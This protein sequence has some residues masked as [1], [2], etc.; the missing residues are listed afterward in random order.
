[1]R[2]VLVVILYSRLSKDSNI[3]L[4]CMGGINVFCIDGSNVGCV[5][6]GPTGSI[7]GVIYCNSCSTVPV[8]TSLRN[9]PFSIFWH[10]QFYTI[11]ICCSYRLVVLEIAGG[12]FR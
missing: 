1:M 11:G 6:P 2:M 10:P 12:T 5:Y 8:N 7:S 4:K 3:S 9:V